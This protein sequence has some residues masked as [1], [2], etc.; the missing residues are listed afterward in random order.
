MTTPD[1]EAALAQPSRGPSKRA[2]L[3]F[4]PV[5]VDGPALCA[6]VERHSAEAGWEPPLLLETS[7]DDPGQATTREALA[8]GVDAMLVAGGDGTVRSVSE[9]VRGSGV[10]LAIIPG[11]TGN[12]LARNLRLPLDGQDQVVAGAFDGDT[13]DVDICV[14]SLRRPE[15]HVEEH[16]FVVMAGMGL[17]AAMIA[18]TR[19]ELKKSVGW[20]AY[21]D[22]AARSLA[23][24]EPFRIM[25][26]VVKNPLRR[27]QTEAIP[28]AARLHSAKVQ[29]ILFANCGELP[30]GISLIPDGSVLDGELDVAIMQPSGPLGWLGVWRKVWWDNSV[31]RRTRR[32]RAI[33]ERRG[34]DASVRYLRGIAAEAATPIPQSV[35]LDG[36]EFGEATRI[37]CRIEKGNLL[38]AVPK[39]HDVRAKQPKADV[40]RAGR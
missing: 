30:G 35:Q 13:V 18:N 23:G 8:E 20:V 12:L 40:Q 27:G 24:A 29:S 28:T 25:Y 22:G 2:A 34:R 36:D 21:V 4:N 15:G 26:E 14:A 32:G 5:K 1:Q 39:G 19:P 7:V 38:V 33:I 3:V 16:A 10:P 17:D 37:S 9:A 31:L 6:L 11:G